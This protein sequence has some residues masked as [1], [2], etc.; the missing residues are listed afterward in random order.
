MWSQQSSIYKQTTNGRKRGFNDKIMMQCLRA[1]MT[2][3]TGIIHIRAPDWER[4]F[5]SYSCSHQRIPV[6][7]TRGQSS[8]G[9]FIKN[10]PFW[11][12]F[13]LMTAFK[14][15][16][17]HLRQETRTKKLLLETHKLGLHSLQHVGVI[18]TLFG[19]LDPQHRYTV[20]Q[21]LFGK[22]RSWK[23]AQLY[24][25]PTMNS[26]CWSQPS[27]WSEWNILLGFLWV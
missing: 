5:N 13:A 26:N 2:F 6:H 12:Q 15:G 17:V 25:L 16:H 11:H 19:L 3:W 9:L 24:S 8:P 27:S 23:Y 1:R 4:N 10:T 20:S 7:E 18:F 21:F 22:D 14:N